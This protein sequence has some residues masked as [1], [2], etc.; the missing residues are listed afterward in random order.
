MILGLLVALTIAA[1]VPPGPCDSVDGCDTGAADTASGLTT[2]AVYDG[3]PTLDELF[4]TC[5]ES[6]DEAFN[7]ELYTTGWTSKVSLEIVLSGEDTVWS[8]T[9][10]LKPISYDPNRWWEHTQREL[11]VLDGSVC[12]R[13]DVEDSPAKPD[14]QS[15]QEPDVNTWFR[16]SPRF[17]DKSM[18]WAVT[19]TALDGSDAGCWTWGVDPSAFPECQP[20]Q[21]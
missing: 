12:H 8:E 2:Q 20:F 13:N 1:C 16:C 11:S 10:T 3:P 18:T 21:P 15:I 17:V 4:W 5:T 9:H 19:L 6:P 7:Y 14:C